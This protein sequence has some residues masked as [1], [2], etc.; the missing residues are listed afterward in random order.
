MLFKLKKF[1][2]R[3]PITRLEVAE[4]VVSKRKGADDDD[5]DDA[6]HKLKS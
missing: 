4:D 1:K 5:N 3:P 6:E 2:S